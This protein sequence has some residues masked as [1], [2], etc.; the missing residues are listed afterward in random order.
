MLPKLLTTVLLLATQAYTADVSKLFHYEL[1][2]NGTAHQAEFQERTHAGYRLTYVNGYY[3]PDQNQT[4]FSSI[5]EKTGTTTSIPWISKHG[6]TVSQYNDLSTD[7]RSKNYHPVVL[8]G[9]NLPT[10]DRRFA[11][12]WEK[13]KSP[14][15]TWKQAVDL[16]TAQLKEKVAALAPLRL[17]SLSGYTVNDELRY[18]AT[19]GE[20]TSSDWKGEWLYYA[21]RTGVMQVGVNAAEWKPTYLHG[22]SVDGE[23][24][25]DSVWE[26]YTGPGY[27][28]RLWYYEDNET[29]EGYETF[30]NGM[31]K[32]GYKPRMVTGHY[33]EECGVRYVGY[34]S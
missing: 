32:R 26:R 34:F 6:L 19:W 1:G 7:L 16:T 8:N 14:I 29:A 9:Y 30:F 10:G 23:P 22:H 28:V 2:L 21:N 20:R 5:W 31:T 12:I 33:S 18:A 25:F 24:V 11:T 17:T 3:S 4:L 15:K 13:P 27:G